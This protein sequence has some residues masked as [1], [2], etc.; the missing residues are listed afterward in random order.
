M[1]RRARLAC[2]TGQRWSPQAPH[3]TPLRRRRS[4]GMGC[5]APCEA[6]LLPASER[7]EQGSPMLEEGNGCAPMPTTGY[8]TLDLPV[9]DAVRWA[10]QCLPPATP[11]PAGR[12]AS[13]VPAWTLPPPHRTV[14]GV[15][16]S[17][18]RPQSGPYGV[19]ADRPSRR[20]AGELANR[21]GILDLAGGAV[22]GSGFAS[23]PRG[24]TF[25]PSVRLSRPA[26]GGFASEVRAPRPPAGVRICPPE[27]V[28]TGQASDQRRTA[29]DRERTIRL[30]RRSQ[31]ECSRGAPM[32][33]P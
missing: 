19:H 27:A 18:K 14:K 17:D 5:S 28:D 13:Y 4:S 9:S 10:R 11:S 22:R 3:A 33:G 2:R 32:A 26:L 30:R 16:G 25:R 8:G 23:G 6:L 31:R 7:L 29:T 12:I 20:H 24:I 21:T 15:H 1:A